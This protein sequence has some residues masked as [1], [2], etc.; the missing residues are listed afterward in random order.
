MNFRELQKQKLSKDELRERLQ[1][2]IDAMD[3]EMAAAIRDL[4]K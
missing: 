4:L 3:F 1:I 2:A